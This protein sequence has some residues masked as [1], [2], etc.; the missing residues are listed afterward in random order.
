MMDTWLCRSVGQLIGW[1]SS[2]FYL[3][4]RLSQ[5]Y[6]NWSRQSAEGLSLAMFVCAVSANMLYG[7]GILLRTYGW[8]DLVSSA[9]WLLG[10]LGTVFL[11]LVIFSQV[12]FRSC[13]TFRV[14]ASDSDWTARPSTLESCS[15]R[16]CLPN[17]DILDCWIVGC[18]VFGVVAFT[19]TATAA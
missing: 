9:P 17:D 18:C 10:S 8:A 1:V 2:F 19:A 16:E 11:D 15:Q 13:I 12:R 5:I 7:F 14:F 6:K 4:S 3:G